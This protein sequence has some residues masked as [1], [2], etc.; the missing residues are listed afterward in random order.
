MCFTCYS[1]S[2]NQEV[3]D[4]HHCKRPWLKPDQT[5]TMRPASRPSLCESCIH[6]VTSMLPNSNKIIWVPVEENKHVWN[7]FWTQ[8]IHPTVHSQCQ[9][10][11]VYCRLTA[12]LK[13]WNVFLNFHLRQH[14]CPIL[15]WRLNDSHLHGNKST[16]P[17]YCNN[18]TITAV[19]G[20][21]QNTQYNNH[22]YSANTVSSTVMCFPLVSHLHIWTTCNGNKSHIV[23]LRVDK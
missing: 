14:F 12:P 20:T 10:A 3:Q 2:E 5:W 21:G 9:T 6:P 19:Q 15:T 1:S 17:T 16:P 11:D 8:V 13:L 4:T 23:L 7:F 22:E 18:N